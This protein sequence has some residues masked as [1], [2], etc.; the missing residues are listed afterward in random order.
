[1]LTLTC[2]VAENWRRR[3]RH[4][5][6]TGRERSRFLGHVLDI[7]LKIERSRCLVCVVAFRVHAPGGVAVLD[8]GE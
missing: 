7:Q 1:M 2:I 5:C 3:M 8:C 4:T 6:W